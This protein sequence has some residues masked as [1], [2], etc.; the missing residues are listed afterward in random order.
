MLLALGQAEAAFTL[1]T[2]CEVSGDGVYLSDL[3]GSKTGEAI[4]AIMIDVS[5]SWGTIREYSSQDLI[6]L[7][8]ERAQGIEVVSDEADM[9]TSISRSSR[10]FGSE[11]VLELLRAEL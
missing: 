10:A 3:V 4:P 8:N 9:K 6:K 11:E 7:I 1:K 5:P 2:K